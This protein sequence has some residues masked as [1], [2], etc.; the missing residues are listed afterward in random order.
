MSF[1]KANKKRIFSPQNG[2]MVA[3]EEVPD[4][5]FAQKMIGDGLAVI[6]SD[7]NIYAPIDGIV[8]MIAENKHAY[9][10]RAD[11]GIG[12][13]VHAGIDT[14]ELEGEGFQVF[15]KQG[16]S[17]RMGDLLAKVNLDLIT[18][19]G[20]K[21]HTVVVITNMDKVKKL[22]CFDGDAKAMDTVIMEYTIK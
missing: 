18:T 2:I 14:V 21:T 8:E 1:F 5:S 17:V 16:Q 4:E 11:D 10:L 19:K 20:Y 3:I 22:R 15:V 12:V 7:N 9:A 13:L 6:P